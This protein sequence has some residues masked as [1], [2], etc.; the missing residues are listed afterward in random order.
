VTLTRGKQLSGCAEVTLPPELGLHPV[1]S[2][3][4]LIARVQNMNRLLRVGSGVLTVVFGLAH[5][6]H[7]QTNTIQLRNGSQTTTILPSTGTVRIQI[8]DAPDGSST[9]YLN[10]STVAP[11]NNAGGGGL[12]YGAST[13]QNSL[14]IKATSNPYLF[15]ISY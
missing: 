12:L 1:V 2:Q 13:P 4:H 14:E 8:P 3:R 15:N 9:L 11:A 7:G 5:S 6:L 10:T